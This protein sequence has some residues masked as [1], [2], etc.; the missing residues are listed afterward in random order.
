LWYRFSSF[1]LPRLNLV[2]RSDAVVIY[3]N[4]SERIV[5]DDDESGDD[6]S[7]DDESDDDE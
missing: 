6:E 5:G 7:D 2:G 1:L 4:P 3:D